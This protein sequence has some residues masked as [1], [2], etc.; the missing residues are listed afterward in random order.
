MQFLVHFMFDKILQ[1]FDGEKNLSIVHVDN[2]N[3]EF[4]SALDQESNEL[5]S[6]YDFDEEMT[7]IQMRFVLC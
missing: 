5:V 6:I 3:I 2:R 4:E 1:V 7:K